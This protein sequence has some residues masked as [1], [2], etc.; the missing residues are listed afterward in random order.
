MNRVQA[1]CTSVRRVGAIEEG[2]LCERERD[3]NAR[4]NVIEGGTQSASE[5][6]EQH[7]IDGAKRSTIDRALQH[8]ID[9]AKQSP[10]DG[11]KRS[12]A[13]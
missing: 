1:I 12:A 10:I 3:R 4:R 9:G 8:A 13:S 6:A 5:G 11:A 7:A 2:V